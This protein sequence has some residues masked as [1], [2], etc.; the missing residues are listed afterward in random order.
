MVEEQ[1]KATSQSSDCESINQSEFS[2][3]NQNSPH[4][5]KL[6][7][8]I[9][10]SSVPNL[11]V[12]GT[13]LAHSLG[14]KNSIP[15]CCL[16]TVFQVPSQVP[17]AVSVLVSYLSLRSCLPSAFTSRSRKLVLRKLVGLNTMTQSS[18]QT[19]MSGSPASARNYR[20]G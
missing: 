12:G 11:H 4:P 15:T 13:K 2:T 18:G 14:F 3:T 5:F 8:P 16:A 10:P 1:K 6:T 17:G 19:T 20:P 9:S 7:N